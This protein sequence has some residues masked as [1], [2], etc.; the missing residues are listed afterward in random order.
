MMLDLA[1][2]IVTW[3]VRALAL[4]TL[5]S[6]Y[7]DL[8]TSNLTYQVY[9]V[10]SASSD[11]TVAAISRAYPQARLTASTENIGFAKANNLAMRQMGFGDSSI[12]NE[13]L[14]RAVYLLNPDTITQGGATR[15]LFDGLFSESR[16]GLVGAQLAYEDGSFQHGAFAF[17][18]LMQLWGE[19]FPVMG[20]FHDS[21]Y[22]GRYPRALYEAGQPFVVDFTLGATMM[23]RRE[24]IQQTGMFDE[25]FFM[26]CE[27]VDWAWRIRDAAWGA[28]C[29]PAAKVLH[30]VGRSSAQVRPQ[31]V[32][33][34][35][36]SRLLLYRKHYPTWKYQVARRM[37]Q[38]GIR[39]KL[40]TETNA[41]V[42]A[43]Y[44][45]VLALAERDHLP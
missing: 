21:T 45:T 13:R 33:R 15:A 11:D 37:V 9:V 12:P 41:E 20:R 14:P 34:L 10:D 23:L 38:V 36:T 29:I 2:V 44:Q 6:L 22:N 18:G 17:P 31:T 39:L 16:V 3:N 19:F 1:V 30:L 42:R 5:A 32:V 7:A 8:A 35:W 43:A 24:V 26:Y 27:E 4:Q 25:R 28:R 40:R